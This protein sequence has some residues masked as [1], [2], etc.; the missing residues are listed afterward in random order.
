M[1]ASFEVFLLVW[2][3]QIVTASDPFTTLIAYEKN[4]RISA[5]VNDTQYHLLPF[6]VSGI[7]QHF[8]LAP[9]ID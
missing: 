3:V 7:S 1:R 6:S 4:Q 2:I 8:I 5:E 9:Q